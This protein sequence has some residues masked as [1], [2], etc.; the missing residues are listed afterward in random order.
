M[1]VASDASGMHSRLHAWFDQPL[2]RSLRAA[3]ADRLRSTLSSLYASRV[4]QLGSIGGTELL[5][6]CSA[7]TRILMEFPEPGRPCS[8]AA[9]PE[10]LPFDTS[11]VDLALL[12]HTLDF[13][14][15]PH[16]VLREVDRVLLPEGN[17]VILG[18]NPLSLWG[19]R[20]ALRRRGR[21]A[22]PWNAHFI[23]LRRIKD[24]LQLLNFEVNEGAMLY[25]RPPLRS[26]V[27]L[28][29]LYVMDKIG[30]RWWPMAG[31]VYMLVARKRVAG[32]MPIRP[33]WR[34]QAIAGGR[35]PQPTA[36]GQFAARMR[37]GG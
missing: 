18:F 27:A 20:R 32:M 22:I 7:P 23:S 37:G 3:E 29:R 28:D 6:S 25:Y 4:V 9:L 8:V 34:L 14:T 21:G 24:W 16:E 17:V 11:S 2:G 30:N 12:P 5:H 19:L 26:Q 36:R 15:Y 33:R 13:S 35:L 1:T 31:A 10:A